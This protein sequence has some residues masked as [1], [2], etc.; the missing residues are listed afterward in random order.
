MSTITTGE[1][2]SGTFISGDEIVGNQGGATKRLTLSSEGLSDYEY[3]TWTPTIY[4][5]VTAGTTTYT[6]QIGIYHRLGD[7]VFI[8]CS[9]G[10][11]DFTGSGG[12]RI[13]GLPFTAK[14][15]SGLVR[16]G[17]NMCG[18]SGVTLASDKNFQIIVADDTNVIIWGLVD[19]DGT[20][21]SVFM[22]DI[23]TTG[24]FKLSGTYLI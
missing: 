11:S 20:F 1:L 17:M 21:T 24:E 13:G 5:T 9:V 3:G 2:P 16:F 8:S 14:S 15:I 18:Y 23:A 22:S 10:W 12:V 7:S 4:G 6:E 19:D